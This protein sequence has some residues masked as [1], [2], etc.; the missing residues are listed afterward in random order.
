MQIIIYGS[1]YIRETVKH[2]TN[3]N[4]RTFLIYKENKLTLFYR[5]NEKYVHKEN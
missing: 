2:G 1:Y 4:V 5:E 3:N